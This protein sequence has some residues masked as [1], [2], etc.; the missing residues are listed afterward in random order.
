M[1]KVVDKAGHLWEESYGRAK[2][3]IGQL[4]WDE[5]YITA[6]NTVVSIVMILISFAIFR[7]VLGSIDTWTAKGIVFLLDI[8]IKLVMVIIKSTSIYF[9]IPLLLY[10]AIHM[11]AKKDSIR[12]AFG[13]FL[14]LI[15]IFCFMP[16]LKLDTDG[17][18]ASVKATLPDDL[19][20]TGESSIWKIS[21]V[22]LTHP[23]KSVEAIY[24]SISG[25]VGMVFNL[26]WGYFIWASQVIVIALTNLPQAFGIFLCALFSFFLTGIVSLACSGISLIPFIGSSFSEL[27]EQVGNYAVF[28]YVF[29]YL[30]LVSA[31]IKGVGN[32]I[33][34]SVQ[35]Y[36]TL[37]ASDIDSVPSNNTE[38]MPSSLSSPSEAIG[39]E[40]DSSVI[41][42]K[43]QILKEKKAFEKRFLLIFIVAICLVSAFYGFQRY[44]RDAEIRNIKNSIEESYN[45]FPKY[46]LQKIIEK[47]DTIIYKIENDDRLATMFK[48]DLQRMIKLN[49]WANNPTITLVSWK[50]ELS[51][52]A[53]KMVK[54]LDDPKPDPKIQ[55]FSYD[56]KDNIDTYEM[57]KVLNET[58][59]AEIEIRKPMSIS[60]S[61]I[62]LRLEE[63]N[64]FCKNSLIGESDVRTAESLLKGAGWDGSKYYADFL[65][66]NEDGSFNG[67]MVTLFFEK[68]NFENIP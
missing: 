34:L 21:K 26:M 57:H 39:R 22:Y 14:V 40:Q 37:S 12:F 25:S 7:S 59:T 24:K 2:S 44:Q 63:W 33:I 9:V 54:S 58:K 32:L 41:H 29:G 48:D 46:E 36:R 4:S 13:F 6:R 19:K 43:E 3:R 62:K 17:L 8:I 67:S 52:T 11:F 20:N 66:K 55:I 18:V 50:I 61:K 51:E 30:L 47:T 49:Q 64:V 42:G 45:L 53:I 10:I 68:P 65:I 28:S 1:S 23:S 5:E 31:L 60:I 16:D 27:V 56:N 15:A 38:V 35:K